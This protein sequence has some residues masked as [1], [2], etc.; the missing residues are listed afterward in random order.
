MWCGPAL[1]LCA[2]SR[3][4]Q[5]PLRCAMS[6]PAAAT[7]KSTPAGAPPIPSSPW[8]T[9]A[10]AHDPLCPAR[11]LRRRPSAAAA[12]L[13]HLG[14]CQHWLTAVSLGRCFV[15]Q[16]GIALM[17]FLLMVELRCS[18][19]AA[20]GLCDYSRCPQGLSVLIFTLPK[21]KRLLSRPCRVGSDSW[22]CDRESWS[23][24]LMPGMRC[25]GTHKPGAWMDQL[26]FFW[27]SVCTSPYGFLG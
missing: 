14:K 13:L 21:P 18:A 20:T 23:F 1:R 17:S 24:F 26:P 11:I 16:C 7:G 6:R 5:P 10:D 19:Q 8:M 27:L 12:V 4:R 3:P 25:N 22:S 15:Y 9:C 2:A